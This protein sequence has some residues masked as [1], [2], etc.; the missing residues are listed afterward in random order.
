MSISQ[1]AWSGSC[2]TT[3]QRGGGSELVEQAA[4]EAAV[5]GADDV[6]VLA[7]RV[8]VRTVVPAGSW[9]GHRA[10]GQCVGE[11]RA[12][13]A[14]RR[15]LARARHHRRRRRRR[16]PRRLL[17]PP[18]VIGIVKSATGG[19]ALGFALMALVALACLIVL[20]ALR[21]P[22][23]AEPAPETIPTSR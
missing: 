8:A 13:R 1:P 2:G 6:L 21:A 14:G 22:Q 9:A 10:D 3:G 15:S 19:Y 20:R 18:L 11:S 4:C 7:H 12:P 5:E 17:F 23:R 16:R